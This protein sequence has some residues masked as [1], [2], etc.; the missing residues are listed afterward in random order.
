M[1]AMSSAEIERLHDENERLRAELYA[2]QQRVG[3]LEQ[4]LL[5]A[6]GHGVRRAAALA[7]LAPYL[8]TLAA[9]AI[10]PALRT[11]LVFDLE[12][13][14]LL[15]LGTTLA[16]MLAMAEGRH[17]RVVRLD[18]VVEEDAL[19]GSYALGG[20][21]PALQWQAGMLAPNSNQHEV[22][23]A[24]IPDLARLNLP[25]A[26]AVVTLADATVAHLER[27]GRQQQWRPDICWL[28]GCA[29][30]DVG[31]VSLHLLD[32][33]T[34]RIGGAQI[35]R[36]NRATEL[37][38]ALL[39]VLDRVSVDLDPAL[40]TLIEEVTPRLP[41]LEPEAITQTIGLVGD[42]APGERRLMSLGR[43]AQALARLAGAARTS[44]AHVDEAASL[45]GLISSVSLP[46]PAPLSL[47]PL[48]EESSPA[49][50]AER[51]VPTHPPTITAPTSGAPQH[52]DSSLPETDRTSPK[53]DSEGMQ[54][55]ALLAPDSQF[56]P[57]SFP[58]LVS[59]YPEDTVIPEREVT[60]LRLPF[61]KSRAIRASGD[62]IGVERARALEDLAIVAT[63]IEAAKYQPMRRR[64][65]SAQ[66]PTEHDG[67][68]AEQ[69]IV[70]ASDLQSYRRAPAS[71]RLLL[72]VMDYTARRDCDWATALLPELRWAYT[73]RASVS[74]VQVGAAC[75][76][77]PL[78]AARMSFGN[79]LSPR[80]EESLLT[81]PGQATPLA[82]GLDLALQLLRS[83]LQ[84]GRGTVQ[85][86]HMVVLSDGRG[87]VPLDASRSGQIHTLVRREGI[88]DAIA[89]AQAIGAL[90]HLSITLLDPQP[91][92]YAELP[93]ALAEALGAQ[94]IPVPPLSEADE[95][96]P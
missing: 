23:L 3:A 79:V 84:Q 37:R 40:I 32:R 95:V 17:V 48:V 72:I 81:D 20:G 61:H 53:D 78:R 28:A 36:L 11:I 4:R 46:A 66:R 58:Q 47:P 90:R 89:V 59:P 91:A 21:Q 69:L 12:P 50:D 1:Y 18:S 87:N 93:Q 13:A 60:P 9:A 2:A 49:I 54:L 30:E 25:L 67:R 62:I 63:I 6:E 94:I 34:L 35:P 10:S 65:I 74:L 33:F 52:P 8:R 31:K 22:C 43:L 55:T 77:E 27:H 86:A 75:S 38:A 45:M 70:F 85:H 7:A 5:T 92:L 14:S 73:E 57:S 41:S 88:D 56:S 82:H 80:L 96:T 51:M 26:R 42:S 76:P 39:P 15:R 71:E 24:L 44:A 29:S 64:P 16:Q 68:K 19:W 83:L